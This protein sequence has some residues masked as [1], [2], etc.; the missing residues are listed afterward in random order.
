[1]PTSFACLHYHIVFGTK[2][3]RPLITLD[4]AQAL[5]AYLAGTIKGL[6]GRPVLIG[7][8]ADHVHT[9]A[10]LPKDK[11]ISD[12]L[13]ELK[14]NSSRWVH[15]TYA[16]RR[17]FA[18]QEGYGAFTVGIAGVPQVKAYIASQDEHHRT[19]TFQEEFASF[20]KRHGIAFGEG[21]L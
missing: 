7:G 4:L 8:A 13:R 12:V 10:A 2:D 9:L 6:G 3:R 20:L 21:D 19:V 18:W 16:E 5:H 11:A 17:G 15:E 14:G 1:M